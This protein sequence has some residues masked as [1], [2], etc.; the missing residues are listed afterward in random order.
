[1]NKKTKKIVLII[2]GVAMVLFLGLLGLNYFIENKL[3]KQI[4]EAPEHFKIQ[5]EAIAVNAL[6]GN[7]EVSKPTIS[8][9]EEKTKKLT[10]TVVLEKFSVVGFSYFVSSSYK[11]NR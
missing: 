4:S 9:Y 6:S 2:I 10:A 7:V 5:Y 8:V 11:C 1:M 3:K